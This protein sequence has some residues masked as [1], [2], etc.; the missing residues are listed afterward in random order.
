M[1]RHVIEHPQWI[2]DTWQKRLDLR[3]GHDKGRLYRVYPVDKQPRS[4]PRLD[5]L[6]AAGLVA[7]LDS[8][9]GWQRDVAQQLLIE[10]QDRAAIP[11]LEKQAVGSARPLCR[12]HALA[13]LAG[14][15]PVSSAVLRRALDDAH[16][17]VRRHAV[18][19]TE[20][21]AEELPEELLTSLV[22]RKDDMD[23]QVRLQLAYILGEI[24]NPRTA[25]A[26]G[27]MLASAGNDRF[28]LSAL[29]SSVNQTNIDSV[30][31]SVLNAADYDAPN[32]NV[33]GLLLDLS[34]A[35]GDDQAVAKLVLYVTRV[36]DG[37]F[38]DWQFLA[39][40]RLLDSL[41][42]RNETLAG[43]IKKSKA[44]DPVTLIAGIDAIF[45]AARRQVADD[46]AAI[47]TRAAALRLLGRG[48]DQ[49]E[50][51]LELL[52]TLL[53]PQVAPELQEAAVLALGRLPHDRVPELLIAHWRGYGP[54]RRSQV[55]EILMSRD[56]WAAD[57]LAAVAEDTVARTEFDAARRQR[58]LE[59]RSIDIRQKAAAAFAITMNADRQ[60]VIDQYQPTLTAKGD[61]TRGARLFARDCAPCHKL[62]G[63][64]FEVG[65]D[66]AS[67]TDKSPE[68]M[69]VAVLDPNRAVESKFVAYVA[70]TK[71]GMIATGLLASET[72]NS[73]TLRGP[74]GKEQVILRA[75]LEA[76]VSTSRSTM[77][78]GIER[79]LAPQDLADIIAHVRSNIPLPQRKEFAGNEPRPVTP[80]ADGTLLLGA[81]VCEIFGSTL[82]FETPYKNLGYWS[83][84]DDHAVWT[85][86]GA[87]PGKYTVE[88]DWACDASVAGNLWRL[89]GGSENLAGKVESTENWNTYRKKVV[90]EIRLPAGRQ[91]IIL[92]P[93]KKPQGALIDLKSVRL[94]PVD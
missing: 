40:G 49:Y 86:E 16:P 28:L 15:G 27:Q 46:Q 56:A 77:P 68:A 31:S 44:G 30:L 1:Y 38:A 48:R 11:L 82:V 36:R 26:L 61:L 52:A 70:E 79:D 41:A 91:R 9:S 8:P 59:H 55:V 58:L 74:G 6:D 62:A 72:G 92:R 10:R 66:L 25:E 60:K 42:R 17:G 2:P 24:R 75:D 71:A 84:L 94:I 53:P 35:L 13:A 5:K 47:E 20:M 67:L 73:I 43:K 54:A 78:E 65:P 21:H 3:A 83:S 88:F 90:G 39:F 76:L 22:R 89:E 23:A 57:L 93:A 19:L 69:L 7:A 85:I 87:R 81:T 64:G 18:R 12:L 14:F 34:A 63:V 29:M 50:T 4:I 37:K 33:I 51:D 80:A 32:Q 45:S